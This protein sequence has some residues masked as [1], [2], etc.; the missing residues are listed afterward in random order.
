MER[1]RPGQIVT[2]V[3]SGIA[4]Y[5]AFVKIGDD[6]V[7][8]IHI[9]EISEKFVRNITD[10][11][12]VGER[13]MVQVLDVDHHLKQ[14]RLSI[15]NVISVNRKRNYSRPLKHGSLRWKQNI[16]RF[17]KDFALL[18][19]NL[20]NWIEDAY[21][22]HGGIGMINVNLEHAKLKEDIF[23]Y[24]KKVNEINE[25]IHEKTGEGSD[26][27]GWVDWP[28]A[29][30]EVELQR[31]I[32]C[33]E[34]IRETCDVLVVCG[35]GGSYLGARAAIEMINGLYPSKKQVEVIY[36]GNTF[37]STYTAQVLDY[38]KNK[39][40]A[41]NVI[42]KSGTTTETSI[43][44]RL[45]KKLALDKYGADYYHYIFATTDEKKGV[46]RQLA[47][48]EKYETFIIPSD[49]GGRYS[50]LTPVGLFPLA[51]AGIDVKQVL[52]GALK[53][54]ER[55]KDPNLKT[56]ACYQYAVARNILYKDN[57][58]VELFV[59]YEPSM[60]MFGE[61]FK[62]LFGES[63]GKDEKG[64]FPASASYS[65]DLHSLGQFVQDGSKILFETLLKV[66]NPLRDITL[67]HEEDDS[68]Q[69]NYLAG[70]TLDYV[71]T[72]AYLGTL[73]AHVKTGNVPNIVITLDSISD[74]SFGYL[75]YFFMKACAMSGYLLGVNPFNQPGVEV[76]KKNMFRLLGKN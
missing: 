24:Q 32:T 2:G 29:Y 17:K 15:K 21:K 42:S 44:F 20:E 9:S 72:Q 47:E 62:Q 33:A 5:G 30:D 54:Y 10:Y 8:L 67:P 48:K 59:T 11:V 6:I 75:V 4:P 57:K 69:L 23:S 37:S 41:I 49:I 35:I 60:V 74:Q 68:D 12:Q 43:A 63:E 39:K 36:L 14:A 38:I 70:K 56:N 22:L 58:N 64:I 19:E 71:S 61:W 53:A 1:I 55:F 50:V 25:Q 34:R 3:V 7:G 45:L 16:M 28:F 18:E 13:I 65:T 51:V 52:L 46:L 31:I 40:F 26:F 76:Y 27:L 73:E 66:E